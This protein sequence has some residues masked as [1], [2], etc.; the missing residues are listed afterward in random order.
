[1]H[2][3]MFATCG[4]TVATSINENYKINPSSLLSLSLVCNF[5]KLDLSII[6]TGIHVYNNNIVHF[7]NFWQLAH[8]AKLRRSGVTIDGSEIVGLLGGSA[9]VDA[10]NIQ[11]LLPGSLH[12]L[13]RTGVARPT[14]S[15]VVGSCSIHPRTEQKLKLNLRVHNSIIKRNVYI[16]QGT[17]L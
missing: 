16:H 3:V 11:Q 2:H 17:R 12:G 9:T 13:Q 6:L 10:G 15:T 1:M 7:L 4:V 5:A 14:P 8:L